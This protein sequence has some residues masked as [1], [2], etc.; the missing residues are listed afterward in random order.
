MIIKAK[1]QLF[2][3]SVDQYY[4]VQFIISILLFGKLLFNKNKIQSLKL[5]SQHMTSAQRSV[6]T[7]ETMK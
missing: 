3:K 6:A 5:R 4:D 2:E 1:T 7:T